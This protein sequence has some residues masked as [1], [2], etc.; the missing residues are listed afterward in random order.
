MVDSNPEAHWGSVLAQRHVDVLPIGRRAALGRD[1]ARVDVHRDD[2]VEFTVA[3]GGIV[4]QRHLVVSGGEWG[5]GPN[6]LGH[7][8]AIEKK[9]DE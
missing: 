4:I 2:A 5:V 3:L 6:D 9:K 8:G 1:E 7:Q